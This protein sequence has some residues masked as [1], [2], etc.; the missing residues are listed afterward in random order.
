MKAK[1]TT[2]LA[3]LSLNDRQL[4]EKIGQ[5]VLFNSRKKV[6]IQKNKKQVSKAIK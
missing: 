5:E 2:Q 3:D 4:L 6:I 1:K